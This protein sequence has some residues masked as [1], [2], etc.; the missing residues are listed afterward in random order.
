LSKSFDSILTHNPRKGNF[1]N[2]NREEHGK[3]RRRHI[4]PEEGKTEKRRDSRK[5]GR[6]QK[7]EKQLEPRGILRIGTR[8]DRKEEESRREGRGSELF[9][10][11]EFP[12]K[13]PPEVLQTGRTFRLVPNRVR[14]ISHDSVRNSRE[15]TLS[16]S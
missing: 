5:A 6:R 10:I 4:L 13:D 14:G 8:A 11:S 15:D 7:A 12:P 9:R 3:S 1:L 2:R 16:S